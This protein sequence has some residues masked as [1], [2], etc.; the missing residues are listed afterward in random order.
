MSSLHD[1][2]KRVGFAVLPEAVP[3]PMIEGFV[4]ALRSKADVSMQESVKWNEADG[5]SKDQTFWEVFTC[6]S[7][8][9]S[10][11]DALGSS[12]IAYLEHSDLKVWKRQSATGWHR[13]SADDVFGRGPEWDE[14]DEEYQVLRVA[15]YI[16]PAT[17]GFKWGCIPGSHKQELSIGK[18][19]RSLLSPL[20]PAPSV[21]IGTR[22]SQRTIHAGRL[23]VR[24]RESSW[25]PGLPQE[26]RWIST[27]PS[28]VIVFDPRLI[29]AGGDVKGSKAALF[30][31]V[32]SRNAHADRHYE[33]FGGHRLDQSSD[34][35]REDL[36]DVLR[37]ASLLLRE[38][39][40]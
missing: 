21:T 31:A 40:T 7:L 22:M 11:Q 24:T 13:D 37:R 20:L 36:R 9:K 3:V 16:Q 38:G 18:F 32:G 30:F 2:V 35:V 29:H 5:V 8:W 15:M 4:R 39:K 25:F 1:Q 27:R 28:D 23:W 6:S 33:S 26:A 10:L 34:N 19:T 17:E 14:H 12:N